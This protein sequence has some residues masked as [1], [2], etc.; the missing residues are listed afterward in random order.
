MSRMSSR[1][2]GTK[3]LARSRCWFSSTESVN[4][5]I[6]SEEPLQETDLFLGNDTKLVEDYKGNQLLLFSSFWSI[7]WVCDHNPGLVLTEFC[8]PD[9]DE[10]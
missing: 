3:S 4:S 10:D 6:S 9:G 1:E 8:E 5:S 2:R 7:K